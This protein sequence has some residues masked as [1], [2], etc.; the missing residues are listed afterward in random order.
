MTIC[1]DAQC[2][3]PIGISQIVNVTYVV[4][5]SPIPSTQVE[6]PVSSVTMEAATSSTT[7]ATAAVTLST[8]GLPPYGA[9]VFATVLGKS[10]VSAT[11]FQSN[12][13]GTGTLTLTSKLPASL[14]SGVYSD[15][16]QVQVCFDAA[17]SKPAAHFPQVMQVTYVVDASVGIDFTQQAVPGEVADL[18][19][20]PVRA[21]IY[22]TA[23]SDTGGLQHS[24]VVI[25]PAT[26]SVE[27]SSLSERSPHRR[28]ST[29]R[30]T[31]SSPIFWTMWPMLWFGSTWTP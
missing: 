9:Y 25:N 17:C 30:T 2:T 24:L 4:T 19:Y 26:A 31:V 15:S 12:L 16:V 18:A 22:A 27:Q 13:D 1:T 5:G 14:G 3:H 28:R 21:R 20:S 29:C 8:N 23:N 7:P 10:A 6:L 11:N